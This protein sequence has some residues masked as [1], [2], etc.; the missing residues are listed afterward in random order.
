[1]IPRAKAVTAQKGSH[2]SQRLL[3]LERPE[4][5]VSSVLAESNLNDKQIT[6]FKEKS[7]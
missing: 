4:E 7:P 2:R 6:K 3:S 1:M 5:K